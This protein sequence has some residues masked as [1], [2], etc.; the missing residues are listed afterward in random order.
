[1]KILQTSP[2]L[3]CECQ[4]IQKNTSVYQTENIRHSDIWTERNNE[5]K[6]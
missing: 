6:R 3:E 4:N 5:E 2:T 1:M